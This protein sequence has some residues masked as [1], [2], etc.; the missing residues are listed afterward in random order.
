MY[1]QAVYLCH[2]LLSC[3]VLLS[4]KDNSIPFLDTSVIRDSNGLLTTSVYRKPT[5]ID[6]YLAYDSHHPQSVKRGIVKCLSSVLVSNGYSSSFIRKLAKTTRPT[7]NNEP[8]QEFKSTAVL[9]YIKGVSEVLRRC[10][11]QQGVRTVFKSDTTLRSYLVR[12]KDA[13]EPKQS[14]LEVTDHVT[15]FY[16]LKLYNTLWPAA[17]NDPRIP[18]ECGKVYI[19]ET[20]RAMQ[21]RIKEH[22]R[23]IRL[24]HTQT[25]AVSEHANETGHLPL[26]NQVKFIDRDPDRY[27]RRV[28]EAIQIRLHSNNINRENGIEIP[29]AWMPTIRKHNSRST[30]KRTREG[31]SSAN[32]NNK[33]RNTPITAN[34]R[35]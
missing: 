21:D 3:L 14:Q 17:D 27:T 20:G 25:S 8:T 6:Q 23:D 35:A 31:A 16:L 29:E 9:P 19:G 28:K 24:A 1:E 22:D 30:T 12:P 33:D 5:H 34:Q 26:W 2:V 13:L 18:C 10:L 7:A 11:Q 15:Y 32:R 4:E